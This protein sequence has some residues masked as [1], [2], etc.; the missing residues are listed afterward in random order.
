MCCDKATEPGHAQVVGNRS[1]KTAHGGSSPKEQPREQS[2]EE[3]KEEP[4]EQQQLP[5]KEK[6]EYRRAASSPFVVLLTSGQTAY[7]A[8]GARDDA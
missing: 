5:Q 8:S 4:S 1:A 2:R 3:P 7:R 6:K